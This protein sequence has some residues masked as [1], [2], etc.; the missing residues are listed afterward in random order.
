[1]SRRAERQPYERT[2]AAQGPRRAARPGDGRRGWRCRLH[3]HY[4]PAACVHWDCQYKKGGTLRAMTQCAPLLSRL[5]CAGERRSRRFRRCQATAPTPRP[6]SSST[7][8]SSCSAA[9][10]ARVCPPPA[11]YAHAGP[12]DRERWA[13]QLERQE[14]RFI[15]VADAAI[16]Y[17][18]QRLLRFAASRFDT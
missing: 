13:A 11:C 4:L 18:R 10:A 9:R 2:D 8:A 5:R 15:F 14:G 6:A 7:A 3:G 16:A 17:R 1:M 12:P